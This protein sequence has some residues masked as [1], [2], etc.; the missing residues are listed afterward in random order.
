[1]KMGLYRSREIAPQGV[2]YFDDVK[3][4]TAL[5]D[6][7]PPIAV[8]SA[9]SAGEPQDLSAAAPSSYEVHLDPS[10]AGCS[11]GGSLVPAAFAVAL[12]AVSAALRRRKPLAAARARS[13]RRWRT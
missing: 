3:M 4:A 1:L 13:C 7:R 6:V 11:A 12:L 8:P 9:P 5:D 2:V 10:G